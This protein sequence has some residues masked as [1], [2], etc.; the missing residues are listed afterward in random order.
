M[1]V[2]LCVAVR[3]A[4][5]WRI[6]VG[7]GVCAESSDLYGFI[8]RARRCVA[9]VFRCMR[10]VDA[11]YRLWIRFSIARLPLLNCAMTRSGTALFW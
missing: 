11:R 9:A 3:R 4:Y 7:L 1:I 2:C 10:R 5:S 6:G 8:G